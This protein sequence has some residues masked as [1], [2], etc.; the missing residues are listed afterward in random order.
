VFFGDDFAFLS[1]RFSLRDFAAAVLAPLFFGD[2]S[3]MG[4]SSIKI[5]TCS[6]GL[7]LLLIAGCRPCW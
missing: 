7:R 3:A 2:L 4:N 6:G 1:A 5:S